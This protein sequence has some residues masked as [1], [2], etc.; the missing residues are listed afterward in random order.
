M[1]TAEITIRVTCSD[2]GQYDRAV[3]HFQGAGLSCEHEAGLTFT[4]TATQQQEDI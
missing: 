3:A 4:A 2:Q 1:I